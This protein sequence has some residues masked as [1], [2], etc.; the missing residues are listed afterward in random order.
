MSWLLG[1]LAVTSTWQML[2]RETSI[3]TTTFDITE[4]EE[5]EEG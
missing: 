4:E 5:E 2:S 1:C 3:C